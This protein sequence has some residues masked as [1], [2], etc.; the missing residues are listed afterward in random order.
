MKML[1]TKP[2]WCG[3]ALSDMLAPV[4]KF[5]LTGEKL[6]IAMPY[7]CLSASIR[8]KAK[9]VPLSLVSLCEELLSMDLDT[10]KK[11]AGTCVAMSPGDALWIPECHLVLEFNLYNTEIATSLS[12]VAMSQYHC[13]KDSMNYI[14]K[15]IQTI[16]D[17]TCQPSQK[18]M[19]Q[20]FQA[21]Y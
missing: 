11:A 20:H 13:R 16:L 8:A 3:Q 2:A 21:W 5:Q 10:F 19:E 14:Q 4:A 9:G 15:S 18:S 7:A 17:N 12:W 6:V 1:Y